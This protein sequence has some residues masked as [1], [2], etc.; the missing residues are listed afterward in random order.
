M[1]KWIQKKAKIKADR[2]DDLKTKILKARG[3]PLEDHQEFLFPGEKWENHPFEIRNVER[4]VNR[5]LEGIA[6]KETI[7]VSGDPDVDGITATAIM[8]NR[9]KALQDFNE[10]NLDY[11]YTQRDTGHGLYGQLSVQDHWLNKAEKAKA[12]KDKESLAKLEKLIDLSRSNIE[13]TKVADLLIV[14]D[15]SSN[16]LEGIER[17]RALNP[18]LDIIIL[19]HHEFDSKEIANKMDKEVIL[20]NPPSSPRRISQ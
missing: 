9:L 13:K 6:G 10:F 15:S 7:V 1:V 5:I 2:E 8:F 17:A 3:I 12:E 16:D 20:C 4:A 18:D 14:L 19:D 11:I